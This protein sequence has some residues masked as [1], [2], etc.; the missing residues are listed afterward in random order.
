MKVEQDDAFLLCTDGFWELVKETEMEV[1]YAKSASP[2]QWLNNM[3][4]RILY[5]ADNE[6]NNENDNYSAI[7]IWFVVNCV[8]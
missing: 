6:S 4:D 3:Q 5:R 7:A 2:A 8:S 1:D